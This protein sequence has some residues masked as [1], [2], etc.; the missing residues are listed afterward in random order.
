[1]IEELQSNFRMNNFQIL[2]IGRKN[3]KTGNSYPESA[4]SNVLIH[5]YGREALSLGHRQLDMSSF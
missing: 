3:F 5:Y 4:D 1:M 2:T